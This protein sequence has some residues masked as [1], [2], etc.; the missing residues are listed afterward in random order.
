MKKQ[1]LTASLIILAATPLLASCK[2]YMKQAVKEAIEEAD[3]D[4]PRYLRDSGKWGKV[5]TQTLHPGT[6]DAIRADGAVEVYYTQS[7]TTRVVAQGNE[8]VLALYTFRTDGTTLTMHRRKHASNVP[9]I[10]LHVS[11][12]TLRHIRILG[13]GDIHIEQA[14]ELP[15]DLDVEI[16]GAGDLEIGHLI[17]RN[18]S[19]S[20]SGAGDLDADKLK[21]ANAR[22]TV[23]GAGDV[24]CKK[25]RCTGDAELTISGA[26]DI[27]ADVHCRNLTVNVSGAGDADIMAECDVIHASAAGTGELELEG[28]ARKL[29]KE[30]GGLA[31]IITRKLSVQ[32]IEM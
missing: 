25:I 5:Q 11:A 22:V 16:S 15:N 29:Y 7:D 28:S 23:S 1:I 10:R 18:L 26:G 8:K 24:F 20:L 32:D 6:F 13:A 21:C 27:D 31:N 2:Q 12:P 19:V 9:S 17:C 4:T 14:V 3:A 30:K